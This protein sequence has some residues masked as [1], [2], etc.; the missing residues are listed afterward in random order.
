LDNL[1]LLVAGCLAIAI[2]IHAYNMGW[3]AGHDIHHSD[4]LHRP[5]KPEPPKETPTLWR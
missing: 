3:Q 2:V 4:D 1:L 5:E